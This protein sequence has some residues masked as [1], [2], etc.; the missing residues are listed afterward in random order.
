MTRLHL[1]GLPHTI[2]RD[3]FSH[4]AFTGKVQRF[5]PM[6][7]GAGY[8]VIHYGV[9]GAE[10]GA[11]MQVDVMSESRWRDVCGATRARAGLAWPTARSFVGDLAN[12]DNELYGEFN[13][14]LGV[15]LSDPS[16]VRDRDIVCL[17]FGHAHAGALATVKAR[18]ITCVETG[19][20]Y[21]KTCERFRVFES[22]AWMHWH[23]GRENRDHG[24]DYNWVI[25]NYF[26]PTEWPLTKRHQ[27][28]LL[29][30]GRLIASKGL[31][32]VESIA[33]ARPDLQ[34]VLC[35]QGEPPPWAALPNVTARPPVHG[36]ARADLV[37]GAMAVL[38]PTRYIEPFGGVTVEA[39]MCGVPVLGSPFGSFTETLSQGVNGWR[40]HT[41][42]DYLAAVERIEA[43]ALDRC[44]IRRLAV[45]RY[46]MHRVAGEYD[47]CFRQ[48]L[49]L[50]EHG[51]DAR[52][53]TIGRVS[54]AT[55]V[56]A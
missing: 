17:P 9:G 30:F 29:Y 34:M 52:R 4:C 21:P 13:A 45:S 41:L 2:T 11:S 36:R 20:G 31:D 27:G 35:G 47:A 53:S 6:M 39:N 48:L 18:N 16:L 37:G 44:E 55:P 56:I 40:C 10:S 22:A 5:A 24:D 12:T 26:D 49:D 14:R 28:F 3:E 15:L 19:I 32:I 50:W 1:L 23:L 38:M 54:R 25:P 7:R 8:E 51:W 43:G 33:R 46:S 42:G